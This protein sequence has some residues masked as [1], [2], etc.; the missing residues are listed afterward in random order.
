[1]LN[2]SQALNH[3][4]TLL[5]LFYMWTCWIG[6]YF[7]QLWWVGGWFQ[8]Y[9]HCNVKLNIADTLPCINGCSL[10]TCN[11]QQMDSRKQ[12]WSFYKTE[13]WGIYT[14]VTHLWKLIGSAVICIWWQDQKLKSLNQK[15]RF[16]WYP[17][18]HDHKQIPW[19][20]IFLLLAPC[21]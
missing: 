3:D 21:T 2:C 13:T 19:I 1:M 20:L 4:Q 9:L 10:N 15:S 6:V 14:N 8:A 5:W 7:L 12:N 17:N 11:T 16:N 18:K